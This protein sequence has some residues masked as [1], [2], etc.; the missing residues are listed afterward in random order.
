MK[1]KMDCF[2]YLDLLEEEK[3]N[4]I[5]NGHDVHTGKGTFVHPLLMAWH[6]KS[7][8]V[9]DGLEFPISVA[10]DYSNQCYKCGKKVAVTIYE[11]RIVFE[12][13]HEEPEAFSVDIEF[14][15]GEM[16]F[17][18]TYP[19][20]FDS[21]DFDINTVIGKQECSESMAKQGMMHFFVGNSCPS[22]WMEGDTICVG[23]L[24]EDSKIE[25]VGSICTDLWWASFLCPD[26]LRARMGKENPMESAENIQAA[27]LKANAYMEDAGG[28]MKVPPGT[29]RCT[30]YYHLGGMDYSETAKQ[31]YCKLEKI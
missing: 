20:C 22:V 30:S 11:D 6:R 31:I 19:G 23:S 5:T 26:V 17:N 4:I 9:D 2:D 10:G 7:E 21:G 29:Y 1:V 18:D 16:L 8:V 15:S 12:D 25:T 14:P 3:I 27:S 13:N 24:P 28:S